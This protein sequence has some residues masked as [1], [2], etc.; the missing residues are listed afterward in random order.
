MTEGDYRDELAAAHGRIAELERRLAEAQDGGGSAAPWVGELE[1]QRAAV[2]AESRKGMGDPKR[3]WRVRGIIFAVAMVVAT[4][5]SLL[6][7]TWIPF[8][9]LGGLTL[10]PGM[11]LV[12]SLGRARDQRAKAELTKIDEKVAD[13]KR[14][15][16][17]MSATRVRVDADPRPPSAAEPDL[18]ADS[19]SATTADGARRL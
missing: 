11:L 5:L 17:M 7:G 1:A 14:M 16:S 18:E 13:V 19:A 9:V 3:R 2:L 12:W 10:H 4:V 15:A 6:L 8:L